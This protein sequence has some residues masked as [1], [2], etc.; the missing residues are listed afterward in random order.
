MFGVG[1]P[2]LMVIILILLLV[3]GSSRL[4]KLAKTLGESIGALKDGFS[5]GK[6]DDTSFKGI[7]D[8]VTDSVREVKSSIAE[9][10][11]ASSVHE[12]LMPQQKDT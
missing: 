8:E 5:G 7:V 11:N 2:E 10:K 6:S 4:P 1:Q 12:N 3:F 9:V